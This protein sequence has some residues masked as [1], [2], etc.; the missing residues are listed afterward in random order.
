[1]VVHC[2]YLSDLCG[3]GKSV[4]WPAL[5][6]LRWRPVSALQQRAKGGWAG[7]CRREPSPLPRRVVPASSSRLSE[8]PCL[9][10]HLLAFVLPSTVHR[11]PDGEESLHVLARCSG[12]AD[13]N[14]LISWYKEQDIPVDWMLGL[15]SCQAAILCCVISIVGV[16]LISWNSHLYSLI[17]SST[18]S[19]L[20]RKLMV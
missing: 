12:A 4:V 7:G 16:Y 19:G 2:L 5:V 14:N 9:R 15:T 20:F 6:R 1:M 10:P 17:Q 18:W 11:A 3:K 8:P 13:K